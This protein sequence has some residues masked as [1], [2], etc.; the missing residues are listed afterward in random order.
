MQNLKKIQIIKPIFFFN[1]QDEFFFK[2]YYKVVFFILSNILFFNIAIIA[3]NDIKEHYLSF[4][5]Y[6]VLNVFTILFL[7]SAIKLKNLW[8]FG[9]YSLL[10]LMF[11]VLG[12]LN[13]INVFSFDI[14]F[15]FII[16]TF[17]Y[18]TIKSFNWVVPHNNYEKTLLLLDF[19]IIEDF[20]KEMAYHYYDMP[21]YKD[22]EK[23]RMLREE[24]IALEKYN[25]M[26]VFKNKIK[27]EQLS[28]YIGNAPSVNIPKSTLLIIYKTILDFCYQGFN[29]VE[30]NPIQLKIDWSNVKND[31][32]E[33]KYVCEFK[34]EIKNLKSIKV[35]D[36]YK[37]FSVKKE[38]P[39]EFNENLINIKNGIDGIY[40]IIKKNK[41]GVKIKHGL[42]NDEYIIRVIV[43]LNQS[44]SAETVFEQLNYEK[45]EQ[46]KSIELS[47]SSGL[48][49]NY[50][51]DNK[52]EKKI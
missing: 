32:L 52:Q 20:N 28:K 31:L 8:C 15:F 7:N 33:S 29:T 42:K 25:S 38:H 26:I 2:Y 41:M 19:M 5:L 14:I 39:E 27:S 9:I 17:V 18:L 16:N 10:Y 3:H 45:M 48:T 51:T 22:N 49:T 24:L 36:R 50:Q 46:I 37:N 47:K 21:F 30:S 1:E 35:K 4:A 13:I 12:L 40:A 23:E 44:N 11:G 6:L 34:I 43:D